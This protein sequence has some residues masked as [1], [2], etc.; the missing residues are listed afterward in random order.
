LSGAASRLARA[1]DFAAIAALLDGAF[2]DPDETALVDALRAERAV[3]A[4][5]VAEA[6]GAIAGH[7]VFSRVPVGQEAVASGVVRHACAFEALGQDAREGDPPC[8]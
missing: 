4:E 3:T 2:A 8:P 1:E 5:Q 6:G 7:A